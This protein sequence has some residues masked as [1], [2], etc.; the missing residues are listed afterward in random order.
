MKVGAPLK[1]AAHLGCSDFYQC[2]PH[3]PSRGGAA[4]FF[5]WFDDNS[6]YCLSFRSFRVGG[7]EDSFKPSEA[8]E[9]EFVGITQGEHAGDP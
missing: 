3:H 2:Y 9:P 1:R 4:S 7:T 6:L 5:H 8:E